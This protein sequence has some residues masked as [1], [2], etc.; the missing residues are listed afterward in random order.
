MRRSRA[1]FAVAALTASCRVFDPG[2]PVTD[3]AAPPPPAD[4]APAPG[5]SEPDAPDF[6]DAADNPDHPDEVAVPGPPD[7]V[8]CADGTREGFVSLDDWMS[9][10]GCAGAWSVPGLLSA[11]ARLPACNRT[12]GNDGSNP[13]GTGCTVTDLCAVGWHV[14]SDAADVRRSSPSGC[15]SA[16]TSSEP[17]FFLV[18]AGA[19]PQ[20]ICTPDRAAQNDLHGC[21]TLGQSESA[22]CDPLNRRLTFAECQASQG[23]WS[24]GGPG[25]HLAEAALVA[26]AS[27]ALGG[28]L[29]CR[30]N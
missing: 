29:C 6:P 3:D 28:V 12:A 5:D 7:Q 15:E 25:E 20:G 10:A 18:L 4:A 27:P 2:L 8:G 11:D 9:I 17:R 1:L 14:C 21:G 30:N 19:S 16:V 24:C 13:G 26:K 22:A 23:V